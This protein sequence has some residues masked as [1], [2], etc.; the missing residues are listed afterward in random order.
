MRPVHRSILLSFQMFKVYTDAGSGS[1]FAIRVIRGR[2]SRGK[3]CPTLVLPGGP[4]TQLDV[5]SS[6]PIKTIAL[7][8][9]ESMYSARLISGCNLVLIFPWIA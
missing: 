1:L 4:L 8:A 3:E 9:N 6:A 2:T 7:H 5:L